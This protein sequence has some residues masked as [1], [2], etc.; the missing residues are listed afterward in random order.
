MLQFLFDE[1]QDYLAMLYDIQSDDRIFTI[2]KSFLYTKRTEVS[3]PQ[4]EF[5][6]LNSELKSATEKKVKL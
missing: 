1:M 4:F 6:V 5:G 2:T 3:K